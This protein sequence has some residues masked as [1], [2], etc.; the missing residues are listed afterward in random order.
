MS[1]LWILLKWVLLVVS[2]ERQER[3]LLNA[4]EGQKEKS[5]LQEHISITCDMMD[6][7]STAEPFLLWLFKDYK[8]WFADI[9]PS[10]S[11]DIL[12][13]PGDGW[14]HICESCCSLQ[15]RLRQSFRSPPI[16]ET[17]REKEE[18]WAAKKKKKKD[19]SVMKRDWRIKAGRDTWRSEVNFSVFF[20]LKKSRRASECCSFP[21]MWIPSNHF[22]QATGSLS[23]ALTAF[24]FSAKRA[25]SPQRWQLSVFSEQLEKTCR[26]DA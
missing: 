20:I 13:L 6:R 2:K 26:V 14:A 17:E 9:S 21:S 16:A 11:P 24:S 12:E 15:T 5:P 25:F 7:C 1:W 18:W 23:G 22:K 19:M 3:G 10:D 4:E 8:I